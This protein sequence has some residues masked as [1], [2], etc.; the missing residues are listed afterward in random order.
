MVRDKKRKFHNKKK[1]DSSS[2]KGRKFFRERGCRFC[3]D[4]VDTVDYKDIARLKRFVAE[5]GK[6]LP[7]RMTGNCAKHQRVVARAIKRARYIAL[8]PFVGD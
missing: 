7:S 8:L 2:A 5:K 3:M 1:R 4:K 6:I